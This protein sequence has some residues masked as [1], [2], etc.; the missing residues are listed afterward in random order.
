MFDNYDHLININIFDFNLN[1]D[2]LNCLLCTNSLVSDY[3]FAANKNFAKLHLN[4][5]EKHFL[6]SSCNKAQIHL[7]ANFMW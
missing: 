2:D 6:K 4:F 7:T 3:Y 1:F 5:I